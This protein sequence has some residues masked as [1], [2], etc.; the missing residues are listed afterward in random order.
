MG[1]RSDCGYYPTNADRVLRSKIVHPMFNIGFTPHLGGRKGTKMYLIGRYLK[2]EMSEGTIGILLNI[3][4]ALRS[5]VC[6]G[7]GPY[8]YVNTGIVEER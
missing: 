2:A 8:T 3:S 7:L 1:D 4:R 6:K 5:S